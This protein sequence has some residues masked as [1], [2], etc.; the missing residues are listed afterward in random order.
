MELAREG[1]ECEGEAPKALAQGAHEDAERGET[2][3]V[4]DVRRWLKA[5]G[6]L[7]AVLRE[8]PGPEM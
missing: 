7:Q 6:S 1:F 3:A 2:E 5:S 4:P 8:V